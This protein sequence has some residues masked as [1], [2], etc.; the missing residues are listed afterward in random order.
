MSSSDAIHWG[1]ITSQQHSRTDKAPSKAPLPR[2]GRKR[3]ANE[4]LLFQPWFLPA[5]IARMVRWL[6]PPDYRLRMHDYFNDW[7]CMRC[8]RSGVVYKS[9][10]MCGGCVVTVFTRLQ[11]SAKRRLAERSPRRYGRQFIEKA[12]EA[13][14]FLRGLPLPPNRASQPRIK[15]V[16][17]GSP[18]IDAFDRYT[19]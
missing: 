11:V 17:L 3:V 10:G 19:E 13:R 18:V 8:G 9:N 15:S 7:G 12:E 2:K 14:K 16:R 1:F 4:E 6:L 5:R